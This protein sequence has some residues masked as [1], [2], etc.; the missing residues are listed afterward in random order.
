MH[1]LKYISSFETGHHGACTRIFITAELIKAELE[2]A[3]KTGYHSQLQDGRDMP[4][5]NSK[6]M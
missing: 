5:Q 2:R 6:K 1:I 4:P 3:L